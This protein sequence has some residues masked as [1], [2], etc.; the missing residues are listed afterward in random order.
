VSA[1]ER[2]RQLAAEATE[3]E[4]GWF[5]DSYASIHSRELVES[6]ADVTEVARVW[7]GVSRFN[8]GTATRPSAAR[9]I[10]LAP[11]MAVLF[12]DFVAY[13]EHMEKH[14]GGP[15]AGSSDL[16]ARAARL[17]EDAA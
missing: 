10:A 7:A 6:D 14:W 15:I 11:D 16:L 8:G 3:G 1:A 12:A 17:A 2:F 9:L 4:A 13:A 5:Y